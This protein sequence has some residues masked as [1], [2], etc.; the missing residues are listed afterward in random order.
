M[1]EEAIE[2]CLRAFCCFKYK[3]E[4]RL[5]IV[6]GENGGEEAYFTKT[7]RYKTLYDSIDEQNELVIKIREN[8]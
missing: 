7:N 6:P 3:C 4:Y 1:K 5:K 8:E 2:D